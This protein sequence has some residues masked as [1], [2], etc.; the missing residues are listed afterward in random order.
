MP[1]IHEYQS[2]NPANPTSKP[3]TEASLSFQASNFLGL[4]VRNRT[5]SNQLTRRRTYLVRICYLIALTIA[6]S[7]AS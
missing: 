6:A 2:R 7:L 5:L 1:L 3:T 4:M